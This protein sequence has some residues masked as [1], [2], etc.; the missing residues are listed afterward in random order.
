MST[1]SRG[2]LLACSALSLGLFSPSAWAVGGV[3]VD[4]NRAGA[5][6][7]VDGADTYLS[8]PNIVMG[9]SP[10]AHEVSVRD[11]CDVG[12]VTVAVTDD[13]VSKVNVTMEPGQG[14]LKIQPLP[15]NINIELDGA[16]VRGAAG[17]LHSVACG[18]HTIRASLD[19]Y[20]STMLNV[21]V[22]AGETLVLPIV[23]ERLG[24]GTLVVDVTP[25]EAVVELDGTELGAGDHT[26]DTLT[27]GPHVVAARLDGFEMAEQQLVLEDGQTLEI[28][29]SLEKGAAVATAATPRMPS[30]GPKPIRVVGY[31]LMGL[32]AVSGA[33]AIVTWSQGRAVYKEY[34]DRAA[35]VDAGER[36]PAYATDFHDDQVKPLRG[37]V[38]ATTT[39]ALLL[40]GSGLT[41]SIAF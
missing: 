27:A 14:T 30:T 37:P 3:Q 22:G 20:L 18:P 17:R 39:G 8:T 26:L 41:L 1:T 33:A 2:A 38:Y 40:L 15:D 25:D 36:P 11:G 5:R 12:T 34:L 9:L 6:I 13:T 28:A 7:F 23:L 10:G 35:L 32:G 19:G 16:P 4:A 31:G 29:L 24:S 21:D